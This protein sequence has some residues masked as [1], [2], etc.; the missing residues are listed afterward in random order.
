[1]Y[2]IVDFTVEYRNMIDKF[3]ECCEY[4]VRK[5]EISVEKW[6]LVEELVKVLKIR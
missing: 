4:K 6:R 1:M 2:A 3:T 5:L